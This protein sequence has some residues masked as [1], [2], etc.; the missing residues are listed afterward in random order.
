MHKAYNFFAN[1]PFYLR[2]AEERVWEQGEEHAAMRPMQASNSWPDPEQAH[3]QQ[4][5]PAS[6]PPALSS[7]DGGAAG[8]EA[9][10]QARQQVE[11]VRN[12]V[13]RL[14]SKNQVRAAAACARAC[15]PLSAWPSF[16]RSARDRPRPMGS[17]AG[18]EPL[19][20]AR[21]QVHYDELLPLPFA[22][23]VSARCTQAVHGR[24]QPCLG[25][26]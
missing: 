2:M 4:Q 19:G 20:P 22:P 18:P 9:E 23:Q 13:A 21:A 17:S 16:G 26:R 8:A 25:Q 14:R 7:M 1:G 3:Q 5:G 11:Q 6:G 12:Q 10:Q 15:M 24:W